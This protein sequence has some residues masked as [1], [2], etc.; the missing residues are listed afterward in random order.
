MSLPVLLLFIDVAFIQ[1]NTHPFS[2][3]VSQIVDIISR[4]FPALRDNMPASQ[5]TPTL[6]VFGFDTARMQREL[7]IEFL[8]FEKVVVD[9]VGARVVLEKRCSV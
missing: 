6:G 7:G 9:T 4:N 3:S 5:T 2:Q 8:L 1:H